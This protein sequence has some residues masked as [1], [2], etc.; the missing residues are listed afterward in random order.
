MKLPCADHAICDEQ[1][2]RDY[3]LARDHP[4]GRGKARFFEALGFS[5]ERWRELRVALLALAAEGD[6]TASTPSVFGQK[7]LLE[8]ILKGPSGRSASVTTVW[9]VLVGE[10]RPRLVTARPADIR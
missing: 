4:V 8:G 9:I 5:R 7:Y 6:A 10:E 1:K 2:V 3:L